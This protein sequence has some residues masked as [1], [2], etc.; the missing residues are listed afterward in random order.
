MLGFYRGLMF[1]IPVSPP[2]TYLTLSL[3]NLGF[4]TFQTNLLTIPSSIGSIVMMFGITLMSETFNE[5]TF[6]SMAEGLW[7]LPFLLALHNLPDSPNQWHYYGIAT[8]LLS[9]P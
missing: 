8:G 9:F 3:R 1:S 6:M 4:D 2:S 5:R 7:A